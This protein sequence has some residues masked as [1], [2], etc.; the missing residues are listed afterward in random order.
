V[1][2]SSSAYVEVSNA[3]S[4]FEHLIEH[5]LEHDAPVERTSETNASILVGNN[6]INLA[7]GALGLQLTVTAESESILYFLKESAVKHLAELNDGAAAALI[8]DETQ[9]NAGERARPVN[10]HV[11]KVVARSEPAEGMI[12]LRLAADRPIGH[13][14]GPGIHVKLMCPAAAGRT[15]VWPSS[16]SN[17]L[18]LWPEGEDE[19]HVRYYTIKSLDLDAG[20]IDVDIVRHRGGIIA[21]WAQAAVTGDEIGLMG[22]AGGERPDNVKTVLLAGDQT[23]LP[24][25]ARY[26]ED[27]APDVSGHVIGE[28]QSLEDLKAYLPETSL[29]LHAIAGDDFAQSIVGT[30]RELGTASPPQFAWFAGEHEAAQNMRKL[31]KTAFKLQK[32]DQFAITYWRR[33]SETKAN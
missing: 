30:A 8:W 13:L 29:N 28:A 14:T 22:P 1:S 3:Q 7:A 2:L 31:F 26:L 5:A 12:R 16:A 27:L 24:A 20:T 10:F 21:E 25:L 6:S 9:K 19:L 18:T 4:M 33:G 15:P 23:A 32:G 17:G 11:M